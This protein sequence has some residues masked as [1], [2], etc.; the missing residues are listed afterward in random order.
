MNNVKKLPNIIHQCMTIGMIPTSYKMS[1]T[2][3]EQL[4]WFCKF[5]EDEVIPVVNNNSLVVEELKHY[6]E[7]LDVQEEIN[8]KL[9]EM[10]ENGELEEIITSYINLKSVLCFDTVADLKTATNLIDGSYA[11]TLGFHN[12]NDGGG[13]LYKVREITNDDVVDEASIISLLDDELIAELI[14]NDKINVQQFGAKNDG[15]DCTTEIKK[16]IT[17][18]EERIGSNRLTKGYTL[19]FPQGKY[20]ITEKITISKSGL[21]IQGE[22]LGSVYINSN[23]EA[24]DVFYFFSNEYT[25][26]ILLGVYYT[27]ITNIIFGSL[28]VNTGYAINAK[29]CIN[30]TIENCVFNDF[31]NSIKV[32]EGGK[33]NI[34]NTKFGNIGYNNAQD[35]AL[36]ILDASDI[37]IDNM[38]ILF[39]VATRGNYNIKIDSCDGVYFTNLHI[40]G[41]IIMDISNASALTSLSSVFFTNCYFDQS[42]NELVKIT[43][44]V[45]DGIYRNITFDNCYFRY[46]TKGILADSSILENLKINNCL[47]QNIIN[48]SLDISN[49]KNLNITANQFLNN[50]QN[51]TDFDVD[52]TSNA[53]VLVNGNLFNSNN[54]YYIKDTTNTNM[55]VTDN[56]FI[57]GN[58]TRENISLTKYNSQLGYR[59][60]GNGSATIANGTNSIEVTHN[61]GYTPYAE[62][63]FLQVRSGDTAKTYSVGSITDTTFTITASANVASATYISW[64]VYGVNL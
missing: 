48:K 58:T 17:Y 4:L 26:D 22:S 6:F 49:V 56:S 47:F 37:I 23:I 52:L 38:D 7:T 45:A 32:N 2:Y 13:A 25:S 55:V 62:N 50:D 60:N 63:F 39:N 11:R 12:L 18:A 41:S 14:I 24:D 53:G 3:E 30:T 40:N 5:L 61:L 15:T 57:N 59:K 35:Y 46:G 10:A 34:I 19:Y 27:T 8:N 29:K 31:K 21:S 54:K 42:N 16:A 51:V 28:V 36:E 9:D 64:L 1:M 20:L 33:I 43:G 44:T